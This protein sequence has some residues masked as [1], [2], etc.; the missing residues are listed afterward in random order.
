[1]VHHF[2]SKYPLIFYNLVSM[3]NEKRKIESYYKDQDH[4]QFQG[5]QSSLYSLI[6]LEI[7]PVIVIISSNQKTWNFLMAKLQS[8]NKAWSMTVHMRQNGME[9]KVLE[10]KQG[11]EWTIKKSSNL[12]HVHNHPVVPF[13]LPMDRELIW[14]SRSHGQGNMR[15]KNPR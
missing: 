6:T 3:V 11:K 4:S 7:S 10:I 13:Y 8:A 12:N 5:L 2:L 9:W 1:M 15:V 14:I